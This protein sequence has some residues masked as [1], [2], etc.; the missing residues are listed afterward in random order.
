MAS[1]NKPDTS[2]SQVT[3][4]TPLTG[5]ANHQNGAV[6]T[7]KDDITSINAANANRQ[8]IDLGTRRGKWGKIYGGLPGGAKDGGY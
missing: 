6:A 5:G 3:G 2:G 4:Q 1:L 8:P 7:L